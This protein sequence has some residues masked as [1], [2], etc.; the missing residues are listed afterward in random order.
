MAKAQP[1]TTPADALDGG[2]P[3]GI[4]G[5]TMTPESGAGP[6]PLSRKEVLSGQ[7]V[8]RHVISLWVKNVPGLLAQVANLFAARGYN[9]ES[10]SVA[11][12][13]ESMF[14]RLTITVSA[15]ETIVDALKKALSKFVNVIK[16]LD[17]TG[18]DHVERDLALVKVHTPAGSRQEIFAIVE[19]FEG[20]IVD[21]GLK[22]LMVELVGPEQKIDAFLELMRPFGIIE[23]AR[24]GRLALARGPKMEGRDPH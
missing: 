7:R 23:M 12:T 16:V 15:P 2:L 8:N 14:S 1:R 24:T 9:I 10:L 19:V 3:S 21:I 17:F 13:E 5:Y 4:A 11:E 6:T 18:K 20:K 22:D